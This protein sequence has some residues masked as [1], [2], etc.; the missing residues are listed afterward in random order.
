MIDSP[1]IGSVDLATT[2]TLTIAVG[3]SEAA[4]MRCR[5]QLETA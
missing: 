1:V 3:G 5:P 4:F 2:G